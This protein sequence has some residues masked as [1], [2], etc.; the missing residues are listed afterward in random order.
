MQKTLPLIKLAI[1]LAILPPFPSEQTW[2]VN[3]IYVVVVFGVSVISFV[4]SVKIIS[5]VNTREYHAYMI[6]WVPTT[7]NMI[8][9]ENI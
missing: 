6:E 3:F 1:S 2:R 7:G 9:R 4:L 5:K 8:V